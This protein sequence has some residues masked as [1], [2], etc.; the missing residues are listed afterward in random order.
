MVKRYAVSTAAG[1]ITTLALCALFAVIA[2]RSTDPGGLYKPLGYAAYLCGCA[3]CSVAAAKISD[4]K[5]LIA[6]TLSCGIYTLITAA[7]SLLF[8]DSTTA[9]FLISLI[10]YIA[11]MILSLIIGIISE[12][13]GSSPTRSRK[14]MMKR[15]KKR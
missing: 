8:R 10:F 5:A 4:D 15:M 2:S 12:K 7:L 13:R 3:A 9:P 11:G 1:I 6:S 14:N